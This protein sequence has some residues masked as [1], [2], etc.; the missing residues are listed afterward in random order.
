MIVDCLLPPRLRR[1]G[2]RLPAITPKRWVRT[3]AGVCKS[4]NGRF[5]PIDELA[6]LAVPA[7]SQ[8][9]PEPGEAAPR[10][11]G[12][13]RVVI[14]YGGGVRREVAPVDRDPAPEAG[15]AAAQSVPSEPPRWE[16]NGGER[17]CAQN[18]LGEIY[19]RRG[20]AVEGDPEAAAMLFR[21]AESWYRKAADQQYSKAL[22]NLGSLYERG[23]GRTPDPLAALACYEAATGEKTLLAE[24]APP[25]DDSDRPDRP[26]APRCLP[27]EVRQRILTRGGS[28]GER[29][30][31]EV[32]RPSLPARDAEYVAE[33]EK[34]QPLFLRVFGP[35]SIVSVDLN[36]DSIWG[37]CRQDGDGVSCDHEIELG[38]DREKFDL[39]ARDEVGQ[40]ADFPFTLR[41]PN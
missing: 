16:E 39:E 19:E 24:L 3:T 20:H 26:G 36:R 12:P 7:R 22:V 2:R 35:F 28:V 17:A 8:P 18:Y 38:E 6:P 5:E 32:T 15:R 29:P 23:L 1:L 30:R 41:P 34:S 31:I 14:D 21:Q 40:F 25:C 9:A 37:D 11:A 10:P 33:A 27:A 4:R 13:F